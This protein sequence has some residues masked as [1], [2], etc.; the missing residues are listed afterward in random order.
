MK[1][2]KIAVPL[3]VLLG[4]ILFNSTFS[5]AK[6]AYSKATGKP[7]TYCHVDVKKNPADLKDAGKY[8]KEHKSLDGFTEAK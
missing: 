5:F 4:G 3:V 7:C 8:Y 6:P 1:H 2:L